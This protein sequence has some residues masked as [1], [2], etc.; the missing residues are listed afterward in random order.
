MGTQLIVKQHEGG[1]FSN[2]NKVATFL[3]V[4][5]GISNIKWELYGQ[6]Y[7]AFAYNCGEV[8][9]NLFEPYNNGNKITTIVELTEYVQ[10]E[11]TG[12]G[13]H[14]YYINTNNNWRVELNKTLAFFKPTE[15]L[16]RKIDTLNNTFKQIT[17]KKIISV[18]KRNERLRCE[19][20]NGTLPTL[21]DYFNKIDELFD[22][23]TYLCLAVDNIYDLSKF[24]ERYKRCIYNPYTRRTNFTTDEEPHFQPGTADDAINVYLE[25]YMLS[26]G[27]Q[28][29][30]PIS[31]MATASLY[32]NP[33][34]TSLYI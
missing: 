19:Q 9:S 11:F 32:F 5:T 34:Q 15:N 22:E 29:I 16:Q 4:T 28:F 14:N 10:Q 30:H 24:I 12:N 21:E 3:K 8:F 23:N 6:P 1:F 18:L 17:N 13:V 33:N 26:K 7:G 2:F 27:Q 31:N 20:V 25:V